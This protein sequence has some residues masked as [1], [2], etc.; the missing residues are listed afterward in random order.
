MCRHPFFK[1][2][3]N[4]PHRRNLCY[5]RSVLA[6]ELEHIFKERARENLVAS[7]GDKKSGCLISDNPMEQKVSTKKELA[8]IASVGHDTIAKVKKIQEKAPEAQP[9][10][11]SPLLLS[12]HK[13]IAQALF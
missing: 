9:G 13:Y 1:D 8:K 11:T 6:L 12:R 2:D 5:Q 4:R 3:K 10:S 7:G